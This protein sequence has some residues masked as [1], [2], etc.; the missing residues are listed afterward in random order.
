MTAPVSSFEP[1]SFDRID[2]TH[3]IEPLEVLAN[4]KNAEEGRTREERG[5]GERNGKKSTGEKHST[6]EG[7]GAYQEYH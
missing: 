4:R 6:E 2:L 1:I 5:R 3:S 7:R